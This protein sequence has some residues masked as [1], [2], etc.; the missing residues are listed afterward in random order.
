[1]SNV[2]KYGFNNEVHLDLRPDALV[3]AC[4]APR[5]KPL[6]NVSQAVAT[7]VAAPLD[8]P[9]L[10]RATVPGDRI[11][12][13]LEHGIPQS[14]EIVGAIVRT[15]LENG[16][17]AEDIK[18]L[19]TKNDLEAGV[20]DPRAGLNLETIDQITVETHDLSDK[21]RM[22]YLAASS[23][24]KPIYLNRTLF[25]AD[26]VLP[27][28]SLR[29]ESGLGYHGVHDALFP[30]FSDQETQDRFRAADATASEKERDL[31]RQ[32]AQEVAWLLGVLFTIQ[33]VPGPGESVL[34]V[35]AGDP[36]AVFSQGSRLCREAWSY[37]VPKRA[38]LVVAAIEGAS[39][40]QTWENVAR[41][42]AAASKAV[43]ADGAIALCTDLEA[44]P[45]PSM[46][47]IASADDPARTMRKIRKEKQPDLV[48]ASQLAQTLERAKVYFLSRLDEEVVEEIGV[49]HVSDPD[50]IQRLVSRYDSCILLANAEYAVATPIED[51]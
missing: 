14:A 22:S 27:V 1:M 5:G 39:D 40:R 18:I 37:E 43:A 21:G 9:P 38:S 11:V 44:Q 7:A 25:D 26:L 28:G 4:D 16:A 51:A 35:L 30:A 33:I 2:L 17:A 46:R 32:E 15:L 47:R 24:G 3:A 13:A 41:A 8:F 36:G 31:R 45:G 48:Q 29:L 12:I 42:L 6:E 49:A 50:E 20:G 34:H 10:V 19:R 23:D